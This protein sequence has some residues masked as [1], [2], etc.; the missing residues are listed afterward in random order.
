MTSDEID[1]FVHINVVFLAEFQCGRRELFTE[2]IIYL[3]D[4]LGSTSVITDRLHYTFL[5]FT[6]HRDWCQRI[7]DAIYLHH[8]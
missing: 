7:L 6:G 5:Q 1:V 8:N 3:G 4:F 2:E